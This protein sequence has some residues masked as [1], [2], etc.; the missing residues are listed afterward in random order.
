MVCGYHGLTFDRT[1]ACVAAPTQRDAPP[2]RAA[3]RSYPV[4]DRWG[5]LWIWMG[6]AARADPAAIIDIP[7]FDSPGWARTEIGAL[8]MA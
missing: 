6:D 7:D 3:V 2:R 5:L 8:P 4:E 1:G